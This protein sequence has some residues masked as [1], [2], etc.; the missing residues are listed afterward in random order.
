MIK[1]GN[2]KVNYSDLVELGFQKVEFNDFVHLSQYG[3]PYFILAYGEDDD[4]IS[5]E[6]SPVS[7]EVNL[8]INTHTYQKGLSLEEVKKIIDML[9]DDE[10]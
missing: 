1:E 5:M 6:W 4:Q 10:V 8:Y 9:E 3:Y 7:R 2:I